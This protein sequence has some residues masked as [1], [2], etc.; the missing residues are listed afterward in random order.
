[1]K[2]R[3]LNRLDLILYDR[4]LQL[5]G[6]R[7]DSMLG[8]LPAE[9]RGKRFVPNKDNTVFTLQTVDEEGASDVVGDNKA[10]Q[11]QVLQQRLAAWNSHLVK[12][13]SIGN[14]A[15]AEDREKQH[16][17]DLK[18]LMGQSHLSDDL[19]RCRPSA[20]HPVS[21]WMH[22]NFGTAKRVSCR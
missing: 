11:D 9:E 15:V 10:K 5:F 1:M 14:E 22:S 17:E 20:I 7:F 8:S 2:I 21:G 4:A 13:D 6:A 19:P 16:W 12:L 3:E 18:A